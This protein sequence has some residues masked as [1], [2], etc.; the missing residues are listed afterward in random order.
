MPM[1]LASF[2]AFEFCVGLYFPCVG[3][4]KSEYVPEGARALV[5]S[6]YR[7]PINALALVTLLVAP[8]CSQALSACAGALMVAAV[9]A[10][11][12]QR[13]L[14]PRVCRGVGES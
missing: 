14:P 1:A 9:L 8:S 7:V 4:L 2:L 12:F 3:A 5:Y 6:L 11:R 13:Q 10:L